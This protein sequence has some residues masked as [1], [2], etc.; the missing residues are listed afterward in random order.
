MSTIK[1]KELGI[2]LFLMV[3]FLAVMS[4]IFVPITEDG[5]ALNYL[6]NLYNSIS[7]GSANYIEKVEHLVEDHGS[8]VVTLNL[9]MDDATAAEKAEVLFAKA[10]LTTAVEGSDPA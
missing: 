10:G 4:L 3:T 1:K 6:D 5:N 2:G 8:E 9:K 7:K